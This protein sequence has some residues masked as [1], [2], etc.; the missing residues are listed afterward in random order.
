[1]TWTE[2][3][4]DLIQGTCVFEFCHGD[5]E[6]N[7]GGGLDFRGIEESLGRLDAISMSED[8]GSTGLRLVEPGDPE[9]SLLYRKLFSVGPEDEALCGFRMP[10]SGDP[11]DDAWREAI[12]AWIEAGAPLE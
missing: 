9:A 6:G 11:L 12:R 7:N 4:T 10:Y 8:C 1:M 5:A 2:I 3:H